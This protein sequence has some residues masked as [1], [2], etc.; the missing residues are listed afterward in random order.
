MKI[1]VPDYYNDFKCIASECKHNCCIGWEIDIDPDTMKKYE[2]IGDTLLK[3]INTSSE[4]PCFILGKNE[5]CPFLNSRNLCDIIINHGE[6]SLCQI[7]SDHPRFINIF[8]TRTEKGLGLCCEAASKLILEKKSKTE[9]IVSED[10]K[11]PETEEEAL[12]FELRKNILD[13]AQNREIPFKE[14]LEKIISDY[15]LTAQTPYPSELSDFFLKLDRLDEAW[16]DIL[17]DLPTLDPNTD[18]FAEVGNDI[19]LEQLFVYFI[20]RHL[21]EGLYDGFIKERISFAVT[22]VRMISAI[23]SLH[24]HKYKKFDRDTFCEYARMYS[25]EIEYSEEN[26]DAVMFL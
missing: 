18:Y 21:S 5:R 22:G 16:T 24:K 9:I 11:E 25:S 23:C 2:N 10:D 20:F 17:E 12:F 26:T 8:D 7:C 13:T 3:H 6:D 15:G 14:R 19:L 4:T 1:Y